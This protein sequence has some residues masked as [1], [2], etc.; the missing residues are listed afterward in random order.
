[1]SESEWSEVL[2]IVCCPGAAATPVI[3]LSRNAARRKEEKNGPR[4]QLIECKRFAERTGREWSERP[5]GARR[6]A[7]ASQESAAC[8]QR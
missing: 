6:R 7:T 2:R 8:G 5:S 3:A 4:S 1:M